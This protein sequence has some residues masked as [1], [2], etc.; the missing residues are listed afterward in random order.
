MLSSIAISKPSRRTRTQFD[1]SLTL[2]VSSAPPSGL[3]IGVRLVASR[4]WNTSAIACL[5]ASLN[6][7]PVM[8]LAARFRKVILPAR[9]VQAT[10]S[11]MQLSVTSARSF[12]A[13]TASSMMLRSIAYRSERMQP[14]GLDLALD[15]VVLGALLQRLGCQGLVVAAGQHDQWDT[16]RGG[17][18]PADRIQALRVEQAR[19]RAG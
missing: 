8:L 14:A 1:G 13:N 11:P 19:D 5:L 9:S 16:R 2:R 6:D 17:V 12:S 15:E 7:Q 10:A 18:C 3:R 4:I